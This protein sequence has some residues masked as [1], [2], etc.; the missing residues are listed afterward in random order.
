MAKLDENKLN[1]MLV[2]EKINAVKPNLEFCLV[3]GLEKTV[4]KFVFACD[5]CGRNYTNYLKRLKNVGDVQKAFGDC[6]QNTSVS[7]SNM[8]ADARFCEITSLAFYNK[9]PF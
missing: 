8:F 6:V 5:P 9:I 7:S 2:K 3:C 1:E 4:K